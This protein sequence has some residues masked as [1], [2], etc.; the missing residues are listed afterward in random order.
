ML[1]TPYVRTKPSM[2]VEETSF[3]NDGPL[4]VVER[5]AFGEKTVGSG[6]AR[7]GSEIELDV[8]GFEDIA[9]G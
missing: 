8:A 7:L 2:A 6:D 4:V 9:S 3:A 1:R 5:H